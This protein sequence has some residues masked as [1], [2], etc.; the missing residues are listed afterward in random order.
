MEIG[1]GASFLVSSL[2]LVAFLLFLS[3]NKEKIEKYMKK[4]KEEKL[5]EEERIKL[6]SIEGK[7]DHKNVYEKDITV[8]ITLDKSYDDVLDVGDKILLY[9]PE[10]KLRKK[11]NKKEE[12]KKIEVIETPKKFN[13]FNFDEIDDDIKKIREL[14]KENL[15]KETKKEEKTEVVETQKKK[16][17]R[18]KGAKDKKPRKRDG[19]IKKSK[20]EESVNNEK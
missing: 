18:P 4:R 20:V 14:I 5:L 15:T 11:E 3:Y 16:R 8:S 12:T 6:N 17:G 13:T 10:K 9:L 19:Y 7:I 2:I 1:I